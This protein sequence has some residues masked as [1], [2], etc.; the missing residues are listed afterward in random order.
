MSRD[1]R[2]GLLGQLRSLLRCPTCHAALPWQEAKA[3]CCAACAAEFPVL[4]GGVPVLVVREQQARFRSGLEHTAG[5]RA[6][7]AEYRRYGTWRGAVRKLLRPPSI[8][9]DRDVAR[10]HSWIYDTRGSDTLVL[11]VGGGPG[12]ENPR[13]I[14]LN[15]EAFD[16][17]DLVADATNL[18]LV[19][20]AFDTV[21]A[22]AIIEHLPNPGDLMREIHRVLKPGGYCQLMVPFLFPFHAY[23]SD[24]QR[25]SDRGVMEITRGFDPVRLEVLTGPA[26]ACNVILREYLRILVPGGN[27]RAG[28]LIL[29]G[30]SGWLTF[31][32]KYLDLWLNKKP[33]A[34]HLAAAFYYLGRKPVQ[35]ARA[36]T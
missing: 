25:Y 10:R 8:V 24:Y 30:L 23:P 31:P 19:D 2:A 12:R 20:A 17:V 6:M 33:E 35:A 5:G 15:L 21:T 9:Y 28:R 3:L 16:S 22:N 14:N 27:S 7:V 1:D 4:S 13:V 34:A 32:L 29:N 36:R 18:P 11:S 26:S